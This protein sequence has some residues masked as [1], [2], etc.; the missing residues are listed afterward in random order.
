MKIFHNRKY[1]QSNGQT[2]LHSSWQYS[3]VAILY[4]FQDIC[5][6]RPSIL[7]WVNLSCKCAN[8][9][10]NSI[11]NRLLKSRCIIW[12]L[13]TI[14]KFLIADT[15]SRIFD[16][17]RAW[18]WPLPLEC[19]KIKCNY[20]N[21]KPYM[22]IFMEIVRF[23]NLQDIRCRNVN[24]QDCDIYN[25]SMLNVYMPMH[26]SY[27]M[28]MIWMLLSAII[29][30]IFTLEMGMTLTSTFWICQDQMQICQSTGH[31]WLY[32]WWKCYC[33]PYSFNISII[34]AVGPH[35]SEMDRAVF[36][37]LILGL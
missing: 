35:L 4:N 24:D 11:I 14:V 37:D 21:R 9:E 26:A 17:E 32:N 5:Y 27:L 20:S 25:E 7:E 36:W 18:S 13:K 10:P 22:T 2:L 3:N 12:Y 28:T 29:S 6:Q 23:Q 15:I 31:I 19:V 1:F 8:R 30:K 34:F 16:I 33:F